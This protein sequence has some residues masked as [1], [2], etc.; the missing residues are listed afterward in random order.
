VTNKQ[1]T[2]GRVL[3]QVKGQ[4][5]MARCLTRDIHVALGLWAEC[6]PRELVI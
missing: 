4:G 1:Q 5:R 6:T 3:L 2:R